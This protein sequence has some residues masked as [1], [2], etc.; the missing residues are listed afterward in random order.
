[1]ED[2]LEGFGIGGE[3]DQVGKT[4]VESFGRLVGSFLQLHHLTIRFV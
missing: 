3:D 4:S 2:D 1:M